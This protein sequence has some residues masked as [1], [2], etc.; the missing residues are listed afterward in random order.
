MV[1]CGIKNIIPDEENVGATAL[2]NDSLPVYKKSFIGPG[3]DQLVVEGEAQVVVDNLGSGA[4]SF[5]L[6]K[7]ALDSLF[8]LFLRGIV[9]CDLVHQKMRYTGAILLKI[10]N[11]FDIPFRDMVFP[12]NP[13]YSVH[14]LTVGY[15]DFPLFNIQGT[16]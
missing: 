16:V 2:G 7:D 10:K 9:M 13:V 8:V 1:G 14:D 6:V 12:D 5:S 11:D 4:G 15:L 3:F